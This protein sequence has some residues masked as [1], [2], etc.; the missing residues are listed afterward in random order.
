MIDEQSSASGHN[1]ASDHSAIGA[2]SPILWVIERDLINVW[3]YYRKTFQYPTYSFLR[4]KINLMPLYINGLNSWHCHHMTHRMCKTEISGHSKTKFASLSI[5]LYGHKLPP[6]HWEGIFSN[7]VF[8]FPQAKSQLLIYVRTF[9]IWPTSSIYDRFA[10]CDIE[11]QCQ[12][13]I[14]WLS[15]VN[16]KFFL[17]KGSSIPMSMTKIIVYP[18]L[19]TFDMSTY[20]IWHIYIWCVWF[21]KIYWNQK[22]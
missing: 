8:I 1:Y 14:L 17:Q 3:L 22:V 6:H 20:G 15:K 21:N 7:N 16:N 2:G 11:E 13:Y 19:L 18:I 4:K 5:A 10:Q 12:F 9:S